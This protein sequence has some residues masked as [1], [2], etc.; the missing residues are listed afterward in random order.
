M[1]SPCGARTRGE[2]AENGGGALKL[3]FDQGTPAPLRRHL[4]GHSVDTLA[5][6]GWSEKGNGELLDL[7]EREEYDVLVTTDQS[8]PHQQNLARWRVGVVVLLSTDWAGVRLCTGEIAR[9]IEAVRP[10]QA[11]EVCIRPE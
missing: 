9:A 2:G 1:A 8:L 7:A 4:H 11:V 5:E 3:L 10:G 6:K